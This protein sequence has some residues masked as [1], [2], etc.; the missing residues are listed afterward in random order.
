MRKN[1]WL[2][3]LLVLI[4][5]A[6]LFTVSCAKKEVMEQPEQVQQQPEPEPTPEPTDEMSEQERLERERLAAE[7]AAM[8]E[9]FKAFTAQN[10]NFEF[11]SSALTPTAQDILTAKAEL[12]MKNPEVRVTIEGHCDPRGTEAYNMAL[13]E[14]RA[15][16]AKAFLVD[17]GIDAT[18]LTT[19]SYGEERLLDTA[20][21]EEAYAI[22][23]RCQFLID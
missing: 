10:I 12:L 14:R 23:R 21:N 18:R 4:V 16:S 5:P 11:D 22:N 9:A 15:A 20:A 3:M 17:M 2:A 7:A 1:I 8:H 13:G 19:I 6:M